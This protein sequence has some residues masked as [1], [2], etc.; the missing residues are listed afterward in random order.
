M[1]ATNNG[2]FLGSSIHGGQTRKVVNGSG[3]VVIGTRVLLGM[4]GNIRGNFI[5][6]NTTFSGT[7]LI[8]YKYGI[9]FSGVLNILRP[10]QETGRCRLFGVQ[11]NGRFFGYMC[12]GQLTFGHW[13]LLKLITT[14]TET[15]ST[16]GG[17]SMGRGVS[18]Q[19][20]PLYIV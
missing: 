3:H 5:S 17:C 10:L 18:F 13:V 12:G 14:R 7:G 2:I 11:M 9:L 16:N 8:L 1:F 6:Y 20:S 4:V 19:R 15:C